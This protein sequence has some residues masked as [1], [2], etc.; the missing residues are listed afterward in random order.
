MRPKFL[1]PTHFAFVLKFRHALLRVRT[2]YLN[3]FYGMHI[4][5]D[6]RISFKARL[7]KTNPSGLHIGKKTMVTFDTIILSHDFA[8]KRHFSKTVI[9]DYCFIGCGAIILPGINIGNHCVIAAGSVVTKDVSANSLVAGNPAKVVKSDI[10]TKDYGM[11]I[12]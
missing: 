10:K 9:G 1:S 2:W 8:T 5:K 6:A 11:I 7:D 3:N 12:D 4:A